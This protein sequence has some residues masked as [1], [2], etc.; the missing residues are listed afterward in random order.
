MAYLY[1]VW[2]FPPLVAFRVQFYRQTN[3]ALP[4]LSLPLNSRDF[5]SSTG[6][7]CALSSNLTSGSRCCTPIN[8]S[9][10][11]SRYYPNW[12]LSY[13][14]K[15]VLAAVS[16]TRSRPKS[17]HAAAPV[18]PT[19]SPEASRYLPCEGP[20][21]TPPGP[22]CSA[23]LDRGSARTAPTLILLDESRQT[24]HIRGLRRP[25]GPPPRFW[26]PI[27]GPRH[28]SPRW[29]VRCRPCPLRPHT[30]LW[31]NHPAA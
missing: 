23:R 12:L 28:R 29:L 3:T 5:Q 15:L 2:S 1:T 7:L 31:R 16:P 18:Q 26:R 14:V 22:P 21:P 11:R 6:Q 24:A 4:E 10:R 19:T 17:D 9:F 30:V 27:R 8:H 20:S 25:S 13:H